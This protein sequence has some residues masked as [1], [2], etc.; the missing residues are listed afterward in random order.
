MVRIGMIGIDSHHSR[1]RL[2]PCSLDMY[3]AIFELAI[4]KH[5]TNHMSIYLN[6]AIISRTAIPIIAHITTFACC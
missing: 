1:S 3:F 2:F 4:K 5:S 6:G